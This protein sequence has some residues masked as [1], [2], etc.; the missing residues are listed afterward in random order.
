MAQSGDTV[1]IPAT[2]ERFVV[3]RTSAQTGGELLELE[4]HVN[5][6]GSGSSPA[7]CW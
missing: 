3:L 5:P 1:E 4:F 6:S 7:G 2:G